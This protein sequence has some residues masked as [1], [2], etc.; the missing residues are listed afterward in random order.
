M[1]NPTRPTRPNICTKLPEELKCMVVEHLVGD[2]PS[3]LA[4]CLVSKDFHRFTESHLYRHIVLVEDGKCRAEKLLLTLIRRPD[5]LPRILVMD[6]RAESQ[7]WV[8]PDAFADTKTKL[9]RNE[10]AI[11][12]QIRTALSAATNASEMSL[13]EHQWYL[14]ITFR[15]RQRGA[16]IAL[17]L[18]MAQ[19][20]QK[21]H[22]A[23]RDVQ[24]IMFKALSATWKNVGARPFTQLRL[25]NIYNV[26]DSDARKALQL[27]FITATEFNKLSI[28]SRLFDIPH[29]RPP[30]PPLHTLILKSVPNL[31]VRFIEQLLDCEGVA[32][33]RT[34]IVEQSE[35]L[36]DQS[37][38]VSNPAFHVKFLVDTLVYR[39]PLLEHFQW[40]NNHEGYTASSKFG[41]FKRLTQLR[42]LNIERPQ[43]TSDFLFCYSSIRRLQSKIP[44]RLESITIEDYYSDPLNLLRQ[45]AKNPRGL[46]DAIIQAFVSPTS[47]FALRHLKLNIHLEAA[48]RA[49]RYRLW[50]LTCKEVVALRYMSDELAKVGF[51]F[52]VDRMPGVIERFYK[53]LIRPGWNASRPHSK[54]YRGQLD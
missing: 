54:L 32:Q 39:T 7:L 38:K 33:I 31:T 12:Q 42:Q 22:L 40:T 20:I 51:I 43:L 17:I 48:I 25:V 52:E 47:P 30:V 53:P 24:S 27:P 19:K 41:T 5:L 37:G 49:N 10:D 11:K 8:L 50:E 4:A 16:T 34:L 13:Y 26:Q 36:D 6:A 21:I 2:I 44:E 46:V 35:R 45:A 23:D 15:S 28:P 9:A 14:D 29:P 3:L 1:A 18:C